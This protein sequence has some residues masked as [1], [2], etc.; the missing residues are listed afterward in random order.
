MSKIGCWVWL[1]VVLVALFFILLMFLLYCMEFEFPFV[2]QFCK[3]VVLAGVGS[4]TLVD[5]RVA[6]EEALSSNFLIPPVENVYGG[7]TLAELC[8]NSLK[9]FN[10]MVRVSVEKGFCF[11]PVP[12]L[13]WF[14]LLHLSYGF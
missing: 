1:L 3:N 4:L 12:F 10:P 14:L 5:D 9:D 11:K 2:G 13:I 7:K 8:C 6:T